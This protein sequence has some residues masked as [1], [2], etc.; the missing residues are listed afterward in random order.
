MYRTT[1]TNSNCGGPSDFHDWDYERWSAQTESRDA[2]F[3]MFSQNFKAEIQNDFRSKVFDRVDETMQEVLD[4]IY[5]DVAKTEK[6]HR[7]MFAI[8][9]KSENF[10][11]AKLLSEMLEIEFEKLIE[12]KFKQKFGLH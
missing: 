7:L 5:N 12:K 1:L 11:M 6:L 4:G 2:A 10:W 9:D 8:L 3:E